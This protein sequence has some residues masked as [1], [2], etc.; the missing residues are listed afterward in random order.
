VNLQQN[1]PYIPKKNKIDKTRITRV[2]LGEPQLQANR[3]LVRV[4]SRIGSA[5]IAFFY[6]E[7][8]KS[9]YPI[10]RV[11]LTL[12]ASRPQASRP[13][14][15]NWRKRKPDQSVLPVQHHHTYR[16]VNLTISSILLL[17]HNTHHHPPRH[18]KRIQRIH[19]PHR[20]QLT[21]QPEE[22]GRRAVV[23]SSQRTALPGV[24]LNRIDE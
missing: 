14:R 10:I 9:P 1:F 24:L 21:L 22:S 6:P 20:R 7:T 5:E 13:Q 17:Q 11:W 8:S 15:L 23:P 18:A 19:E 16:Y 3:I 2:L 4:N 12:K